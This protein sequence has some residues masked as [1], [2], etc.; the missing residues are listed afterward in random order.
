M[1]VMPA[2]YK[3]YFVDPALI[4]RFAAAALLGPGDERDLP[5]LSSQIVD[6]ASQ[7]G[8]LKGATVAMERAVASEG[9]I[10]TINVEH[11]TVQEAEGRGFHMLKGQNEQFLIDNPITVD[12]DRVKSF[13]FEMGTI[14]YFF[15][16]EIERVKE[17]LG[18]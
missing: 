17:V 4:G 8:L 5:D 12:L 16:R 7:V 10:V 6:V 2:D 13:G 14:D 11:I 9:K 1:T 15:E 18:L 3:N